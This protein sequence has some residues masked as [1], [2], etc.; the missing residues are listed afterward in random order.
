MTKA[1]SWYSYNGEQLGQGKIATSKIIDETNLYDELYERVFSEE[2]PIEET[3]PK[4]EK[5]DKK[6]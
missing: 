3:K 2:E 6:S 4:K 5:E 1:G